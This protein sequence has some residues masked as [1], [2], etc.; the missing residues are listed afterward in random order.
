MFIKVLLDGRSQLAV[1]THPTPT[2]IICLLDLAY[3]YSRIFIRDVSRIRPAR[4]WIEM[5][6]S[7]PYPCTN[8]D[9]I[10]ICLLHCVHCSSSDLGNEGL[11]NL[12]DILQ[13]KLW[14]L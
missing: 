14:S 4:I 3:P 9:I 6:I 1:G 12:R 5:A 13:R 10:R 11:D 8:T 7:G 2:N